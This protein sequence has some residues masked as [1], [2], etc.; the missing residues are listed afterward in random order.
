MIRAPTTSPTAAPTSGARTARIM[1]HAPAPRAVLPSSGPAP[2]Q[3]PRRPAARPRS[4]PRRARGCDRES[5]STSSSSVEIKRIAMPRVA[6]PQELAVHLL[7]GPDVDAAGRLADQQHGRLLRESAGEDELLRVAAGQPPGRTLDR[8]SADAERLDQPPGMA[9]D[10]GTVEDAGP[11]EGRPVEALQHEIV[12]DREVAKERPAVAVGCD[13]AEPGGEALARR[14]DR[15][16]APGEQRCGR[17]AAG[18]ARRSPPRARAGRCRRRR[19]SRR[20]RRRERRDRCRAAPAP[21]GRPPPRRRAASAGARRCRAEWVATTP[22][23]SRP[24]HQPPE[25]AERRSSRPARSRP[26]VRRAAPR[27]GRRGAAPRRA[28]G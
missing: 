5:A 19:R 11:A 27:C 26:A 14:R 7:D 17:S 16:V 24:D 12:G 18:A 8:C 28:C 3:S 4:A 9:R 23:S 15:H 2:R 21:R 10:R 13:V 25:S 20:S 22:S 6:P 1:R